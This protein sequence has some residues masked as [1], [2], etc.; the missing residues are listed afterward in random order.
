MKYALC[1]AVLSLCFVSPTWAWWGRGHEILSQAAV[2][3]LPADMPDF[4][5]RGA[6]V[7]A[8]IS[9]DADLFKNR[10][11]PHL[12]HAEHGEHFFDIEL[13]QGMD[14]PAQRYAFVDSCVA[15]KVAPTKVGFLPYALAEWTERLTIALA[16]HRRWPDDG[17]IQNKCLIYAGFIAHYAED[18]CQPLHVTVDFNGRKQADGSVLGKGIHEQV[19]SLVEKLEFD[20][21]ELA[22]GHEVIAMD[23]LFAGIMGQIAESNGQVERVYKMAG[24]M[25]DLSAAEVRAFALERA[26]RAVGFTAS[27][28]RTAWENSAA[29]KL[30]GWHQR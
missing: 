7:V 23:S 8:H 1:A 13:L 9:Y 6:K 11:T 21:A 25:G 15:H 16:E 17:T 5:R 27:L 19:D 4:L 22:K 18:L 12:N 29:I 30:P 3:A 2:E 26:R 14:I 20:P 10:G 24:I 28:Y